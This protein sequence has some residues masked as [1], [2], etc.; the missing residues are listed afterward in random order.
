VYGHFRARPDLLILPARNVTGILFGVAVT[1]ALFSSLLGPVHTCVGFPALLGQLRTC[2]FALCDLRFEL[3]LAHLR[4][5]SSE[6]LVD[7]SAQSV[8]QNALRFVRMQTS[9]RAEPRAV[10]SRSYVAAGWPRPAAALHPR[11]VCWNDMCHRV[12]Y[13]CTFFVSQAFCPV[14]VIL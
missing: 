14:A 10:T 11:P 8:L 5:S 2:L 12:K 1:F 3:L 9:G 6:L 13:R 4:T 7:H